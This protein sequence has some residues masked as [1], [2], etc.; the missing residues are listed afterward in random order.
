MPTGEGT[1]LG[2]CDAQMV[3]RTDDHQRI[4]TIA[5]S[6]GGQDWL[7][8]NGMRQCATCRGLPPVFCELTRGHEGNHLGIIAYASSTSESPEPWREYRA[9]WHDSDDLYIEWPARPYSFVA[10]PTCVK[11]TDYEH[12]RL[13]DGH[14]G[15]CKWC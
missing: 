13:P 12:C 10:R 3:V 1:T 15:I 7:G 6:A 14:G 9:G 11:G 5:E 8:L 4:R 2:G